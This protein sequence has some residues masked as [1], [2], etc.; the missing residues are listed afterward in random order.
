MRRFQ[1]R[2]LLLL[3]ALLWAGTARA[4]DNPPAWVP[5]LGAPTPVAEKPTVEIQLGAGSSLPLGAA[6]SGYGPR[7][8]LMGSIGS[9]VTDEFSVMMAA[10]YHNF[11]SASGVEFSVIEAAALAKYRFSLSEVRP[12]AFA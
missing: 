1:I 2:V 6:L 4:Q 8:C 3:V 11:A 5:V 9:K 12:Y 7:F 10:Q